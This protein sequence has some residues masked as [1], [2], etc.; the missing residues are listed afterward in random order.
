MRNA[1]LDF[2]CLKC[3]LELCCMYICTL[4]IKIQN[5]KMDFNTV[6]TWQ[7]VSDQTMNIKDN[8]HE[9]R[10]FFAYKTTK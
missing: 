2:F 4:G 5:M 10:R 3:N 8:H 1:F 6:G 9:D 7:L